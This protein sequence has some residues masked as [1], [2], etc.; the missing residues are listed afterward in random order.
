MH[1]KARD[2]RNGLVAGD[3]A[4]FWRF[5]PGFARRWLDRLMRLVTEMGGV[6]FVVGLCLV[7]W[8]IPA[9]RPKAAPLTLAVVCSHVPVQLLKWAVQRPRPYLTRP[10][11]RRLT[12]PLLDSSFPSGHTTAA[13][14]VAGVLGTG[15]GAA[16]S[17]VWPLA[18]L[19]ALSRMYLGHHYPSDIFVGAL[20]GGVFAWMATTV[21]V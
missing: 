18:A 17:L 9:G 2:Q 10:N 5:H 13:I 3:P 4:I 16:A 20:I 7:Y 15:P 8:M 1:G 19:I 11:A 14:T 6:W 21:F 12:A